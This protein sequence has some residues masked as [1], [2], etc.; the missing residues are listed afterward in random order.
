MLYYARV[1]FSIDGGVMITGSHNPPEENGF[2]LACGEGT[3]Y[4]DEILPL[5]EMIAG[6]RF[7]SGSGSRQEQTASSK[8][9][10]RC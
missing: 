1:F 6:G 2:K 10:W 7:R 8:P 4:G 9:T 5:K 3:I